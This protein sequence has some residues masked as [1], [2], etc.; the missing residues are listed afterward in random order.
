MSYIG[1][2]RLGSLLAFIHQMLLY[3]TMQKRIL[4]V[5]F[6]FPL[7]DSTKAV[8]LSSVFLSRYQASLT[9]IYAQS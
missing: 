4:G 1:V 6:F 3:N 2:G 5:C 7:S 9:W 8:S